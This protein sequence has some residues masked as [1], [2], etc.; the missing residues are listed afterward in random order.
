M[1]WYGVERRRED[2]F[3]FRNAKTILGMAS[4]GWVWSRRV[5]IGEVLFTRLRMVG[6]GGVRHSAA[7]RSMARFI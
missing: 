2:S 6:Y 3:K 7:R 4:F 5:R 1:V